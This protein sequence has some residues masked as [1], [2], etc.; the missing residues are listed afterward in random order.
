M[1]TQPIE[2]RIYKINQEETP[3][4]LLTQAELHDSQAEHLYPEVI[5]TIANPS[6]KSYCAEK[7]PIKTALERITN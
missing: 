1:E 3:L 7:M 5:L 2:C 6:I 4:E